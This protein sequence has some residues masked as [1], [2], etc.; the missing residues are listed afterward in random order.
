[1]QLIQ[2]KTFERTAALDVGLLRVD[3]DA[4][5]TRMLLLNRNTGEQILHARPRTNVFLPSHYAADHNIAVVIFDDTET[6]NAAIVDYVQAEI[7][8]LVALPE[9]LNGTA[10]I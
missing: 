5:A 7:V 9:T 3:Y 10:Q 8:N 4:S 6:Y 2:L 1:M